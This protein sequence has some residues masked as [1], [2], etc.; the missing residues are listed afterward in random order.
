MDGSVRRMMFGNATCSA[1][2]SSSPLPR[3][4]TSLAAM[5]VA[6]RDHHTQHARTQPEW[7]SQSWIQTFKPIPFH[8]IQFK[9]IQ[10]PNER[11]NERTTAK[12]F[13]ATQLRAKAHSTVRSFVRSFV[14]SS[15]SSP[16]HPSI[17]PF[18][19]RRRRPFCRC[20]R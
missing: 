6:S 19:P 15:L 2:R 14:R 1:E 11:T 16:I 9:T 13:R 10:N 8:S 3:P 12:R 18:I 20:V 7:N 5:G 4:A 17:H